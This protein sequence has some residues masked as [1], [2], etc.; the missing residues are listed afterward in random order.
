MRGCGDVGMRECEDARCEGAKVRGCVGATHP[1]FG[2]TVSVWIHQY[3]IS[4]R[5]SRVVSA[6]NSPETA[7]CN[8][9]TGI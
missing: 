7:R 3:P 5:A 6:V 2:E 1:R 9:G 4:N 8:G